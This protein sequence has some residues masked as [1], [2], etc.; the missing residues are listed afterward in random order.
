MTVQLLP[1]TENDLVH[2]LKDVKNSILDEY[3]ALFAMDGIDLNFTSDAL[4]EIANTALKRGTGARGLR[5]I[6]EEIMLDIMY[7][8]PSDGNIVR[9][10]IDKDTLLTKKAKIEYK[11]AV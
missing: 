3:K 1:L 8:A 10:T 2:I 7:E 6:L 4:H 9:C 11:I 5:S